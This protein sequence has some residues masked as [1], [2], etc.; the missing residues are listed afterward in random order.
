[1][2]GNQLRMCQLVLLVTDDT[3][4][5]GTAVKLLA[6]DHKVMRSSHENIL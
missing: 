6:C 3:G 2:L 5:P 1:M 4:S